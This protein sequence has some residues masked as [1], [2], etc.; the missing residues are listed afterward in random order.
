[1]LLIA[2]ISRTHFKIFL[3]IGGFIIF[4]LFIWIWLREVEELFQY[5]KASKEGE[6]LSICP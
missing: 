4:N 6:L 2:L 3:S 5:P 1:M